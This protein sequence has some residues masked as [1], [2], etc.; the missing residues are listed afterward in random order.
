[1]RP[2]AAFSE[3]LCTLKSKRNGQRTRCTLLRRH[4]AVYTQLQTYRSYT[5]FTAT[6]AQAYGAFIGNISSWTH[7]STWSSAYYNTTAPTWNTWY[8][9]QPCTYAYAAVSAARQLAHW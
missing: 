7:V 3:A 1:M 6:T 9:G 2:S 8:N 4:Y 5:C